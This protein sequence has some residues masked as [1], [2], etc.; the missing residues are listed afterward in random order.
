MCD[1]IN[2]LD[3]PIESSMDAISLRS[4]IGQSSIVEMLKVGVASSK[5]RKEPLGHVLLTGPRG[6]GKSTL[7]KAIANDLSV[8][9]RTISVRA[10]K[11]ESDFAAILTSIEPG[12]ILLCENLNS[13]RQDCVELLC[14]AMEDFCLDI[15]IGK[16]PGARSVRLDLPPF[17]LVATLDEK[18]ELPNKLKCCFTYNA[19]MTPYSTDELVKLVRSCSKN[20]EI[21]ISE[22]GAN[23]LAIAANGDYRKLFNAIKRAR[24]FAIVK[25]NG[26][27][28][29]SIANETISCIMD[30]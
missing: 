10:I 30:T 26:E 20:L 19:V 27:I 2:T 23:A 12:D 1:T 18:T 4:F 17:T 6:S 29:E 13:I 28:T 8:G 14:T 3:N 11:S 9:L 25:G 21:N 15:V 5:I 24:D 16:G 7:A 22:Q